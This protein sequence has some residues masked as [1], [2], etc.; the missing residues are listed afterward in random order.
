MNP[1][2]IIDDTK[3]KLSKFYVNFKKEKEKEK[4]RLEKKKIS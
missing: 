1:L 4:K 3:E 2:G